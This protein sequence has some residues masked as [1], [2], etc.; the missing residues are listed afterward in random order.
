MKKIIA[1]FLCAVLGFFA[2]AKEPQAEPG[3]FDNAAPKGMSAVLALDS[4]LKP[5]DDEFVIY[6]VRRDAN[7]AKWALWMWANPG[8]DGT[9]IFPYSQNW[10]VK[11]GIGYMRFKMDGS[12]TG[13]NKF[14]SDNGGVG[15]IVREKEEWNKDGGEDRL[16]NVNVS[17]KVVIFS[18]DM[19]TYAAVEY[20]PSI[21]KAELT[22]LKQIDVK[23][24]GRYALDIDGGFSGFSV[25]KA[26][27]TE[28]KI[29]KVVNA[30][31]PKDPYM[32][33]TKN[34]SVYLDQECSIGDSL[35]LKT[36]NN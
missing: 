19:N 4:S 25:V 20:K 9:V 33:F 31:S 32:N 8:G 27:G 28:C 10:S 14:L 13:G 6:Y 5:K 1:L 21:K 23:L 36:K 24:S 15:L 7:Y 30:D 2:Y 26:D 35:T 17:N 12:S 18:G 3:S 16:W 29:S 34:I 11:D 22:S